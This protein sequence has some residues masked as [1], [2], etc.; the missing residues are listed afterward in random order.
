MS[1]ISPRYEKAAS[2]ACCIRACLSAFPPVLKNTPLQCP[3]GSSQSGASSRIICP[4]NGPASRLHARSTWRSLR[5]FSRCTASLHSVQAA[6]LEQGGEVVTIAAKPH[7]HDG[8]FRR[9]GIAHPGRITLLERDA[10]RSS[11]CARKCLAASTRPALSMRQVQRRER[12]TSMK[13]CSSSA[14]CP[15]VRSFS[16][17]SPS[18]SAGGSKAR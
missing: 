14:A 1:D 11:I 8:R 18:M 7:K 4:L 15:A 3:R 5:Y 9:G 12:R 10:M 16:C 6:I 17:G 2:C 13:A